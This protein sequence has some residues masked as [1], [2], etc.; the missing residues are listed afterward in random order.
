MTKKLPISNYKF[1]NKFNKLKYG[2]DK[3]YSCL[4]NVEIYTTNKVKNN[5]TLSHFPALKSKSEIS[6]DQISVFQRKNL[7]DNYK[8]SEKLMSFRL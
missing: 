3:K 4:L 7:K 8:S 6:Y 1:V 2:Q 5:K